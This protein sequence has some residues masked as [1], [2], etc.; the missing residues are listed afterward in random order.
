MP[1][2]TNEELSNEAYRALPEIGGSDLCII[3]NDCPAEYRYGERKPTKALAD[4]IAAHVC[5]LEP[6][7]FKKRYVRGIDPAEHPEAL[8]TNK[9]MEG[10]LKERGIKGYSNRSKAELIEMILLAEPNQSILEAVISAHAQANEGKAV[11]A[12]KDYDMVAKMRQA[13]F[14]QEDYAAML[15][16]PG[17]F[18]LSYISPSGLKCRWDRVTEAGE[19]IDYKTCV[20]SRPDEFSRSAARNGYWLKMAL[21]HDLFVEAYG[22]KPKMVSLLAQSKKFP[23]IPQNYE[24]TQEQLR[25]GRQQYQEAFELYQHCLEYDHWPAYGGGTMLLPTP[26]SLAY[27]YGMEDEEEME[28]GYIR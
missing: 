17:H 11:L 3:H 25:V 20:S 7:L 23:H 26:R 22:E 9:Q 1:L 5:I 13:I 18:E 16:S 27:E 14:N 6:D 8:D 24:L 4:G 10:W 15:T 2:Y 19:I 12:P 21:Q 28:I